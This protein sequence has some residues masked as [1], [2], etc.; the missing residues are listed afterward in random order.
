MKKT[1]KMYGVLALFFILLAAVVFRCTWGADQAFSGSDAN[2]GL[3][4]AAKRRLPQ[5]FFGAYTSSPVFGGAAATPISFSNLGQWPLTAVAYSNVWYAVCLIIASMGLVGYLRLWGITWTSCAF[6]AIAAFWVGSITMAAAGH[7]GKLGVMAFFSLGLLLLEKAQ[8]ATHYAARTGFSML[9]GLSVGLMLLEQQDVGLLAGLFLG[10]YAVFRL[11]QTAGRKWLSWA[12]VLLP[13]TMVGLSLSMATALEAYS[14]NVTET[15]LE[16]RSQQKWEFITQ[17]SMVPKELPDLIA[18]GYSG[19]STG[20]PDGPYWGEC[21]QSAE[22][23][24]TGKGFRNFRLDSLYIGFLPLFLA[25][26]GFA[27]VLRPARAKDGGSTFLF[28]GIMGIAALLLAFGKFSPIYKLFYHLPL[29]G[30]IRAPVKFMHNLQVIIGLLAAFGL[31]ELNAWG[32]NKDNGIGKWI[33]G[34]VGIGS[35][36]LMFGLAK[37]A[38]FPGFSEHFAE[39]GEFGPVIVGNIAKAWTHAGTMGVLLSASLYVLLTRRRPKNASWMVPLLLAAVVAYDAAFL[40]GKYFKS[41]NIAELRKGNAVINYLKQSQDDNRVFCFT[42][43]GPYHLWI[44]Q[45]FIYHGIHGFNFGQM[46]RMP[47]DYKA[48]FNAMGG[49]WHRMLQLS[50]CRYGL[51]PVG[52]YFQII[53]DE[54][55]KQ[56]VRPAMFYRF[57]MKN[58]RVSAEALVRPMQANDQVVLEFTDVLPRFALFQDWSMVAD[59]NAC[60]RLV[61]PAFNPAQQVLLSTS[62]SISAA[63]VPGGEFQPVAVKKTNHVAAQIETDSPT[64]G[65]VLFTQRYQPGWKVKVDGKGAD[66]LKCN[67]LHLGVYVPPGQHTVVFSCP[68]KGAAVVFQAALIATTLAGGLVL[69]RKP[70]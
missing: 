8:R 65:I 27:A 52:T 34:M 51:T 35:T 17:W 48:F 50:S 13:I 19:W 6:G 1:L 16:H 3:L 55:L 5:G 44:A 38:Q 41:E 4:E 37:S 70:K 67:F 61:A 46:P 30:N 54:Q 69:I 39:W 14:K 28:W 64:G 33:V 10:A 26:F 56:V 25:L 11:F 58:D 62:T 66:L 12:T 49:N 18:P 57:V 43:N 45:D 68:R 2:M 47:G 63:P 42:Q 7:M 24:S 20:N 23:E 32:K 29:V 36:L 31:D 59:S 53:K 22:W 60:A 15:G 40:S 9:A 21:G